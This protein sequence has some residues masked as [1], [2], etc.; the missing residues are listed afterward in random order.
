MRTYE[1][2]EFRARERR[3]T[4]AHPAEAIDR[5]SRRSVNCG[6]PEFRWADA[7]CLLHPIN[8]AGISLILRPRLI[9]SALAHPTETTETKETRCVS[10]SGNPT[11]RLSDATLGKRSAS[12]YDVAGTSLRSVAAYQRGSCGNQQ[13]VGLVTRWPAQQDSSCPKPPWPASFPG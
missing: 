3:P 4:G 9:N 6:S 1:R 8:S 10:N 2:L 5:N 7:G 11:R 13:A 12:S